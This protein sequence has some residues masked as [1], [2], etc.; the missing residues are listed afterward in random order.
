VN[1]STRVGMFFVASA[2]LYGALKMHKSNGK[3]AK[4]TKPVSLV[5]AAM[6]GC[7]YLPTF[8]G[9]WMQ[10]AS[11]AVVGVGGAALIIAGVTLVVDWMCDK[12]PDKP[13]FWA[14]TAMPMLLVFG[15]SQIPRVVDQVGDGAGQ[16]GQQVN[17]S[18]R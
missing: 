16:V 1:L 5:V 17:Q 10:K 18:T 13:A 15:L 14:A 2:L 7:A 9:S 6:A 3:Y 8:I 12:K 11:M 4:V